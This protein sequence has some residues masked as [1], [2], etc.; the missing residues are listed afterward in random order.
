MMR[1]VIIYILFVILLMEPPC[2]AEPKNI[3]NIT[4]PF[5]V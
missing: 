4:R 1:L 2:S 3:L 5:H